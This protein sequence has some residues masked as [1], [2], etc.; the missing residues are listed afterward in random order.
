MFLVEGGLVVI[1]RRAH[2]MQTHFRH[3][4]GVVLGHWHFNNT[5]LGARISQM[6]QARPLG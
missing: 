4:R 5:A 1:L 3:P 6:N 2:S